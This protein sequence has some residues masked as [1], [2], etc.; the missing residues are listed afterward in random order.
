M[1]PTSAARGSFQGHPEL[2]AEQITLINEHSDFMNL[3]VKAGSAGYRG[4]VPR[5]GGTPTQHYSP[6]LHESHRWGIVLAGGDGVRLRELTRWVYGDDRPK[7][8]C[9]LLGHRTLFEA[10]RHRAEQNLPADHIIFALTR[11]HEVY[12]RDLLDGQ[13]SKRIVQPYNRGTAPAILYALMVLAQIDP[14]ASVSILPSDHYYAP[15]AAFKSALED[16]FESADQHS[17]SVVLLGAPPKGPETEYGWIQL[18]PAVDGRFGLFQVDSFLEKPPLPMAQK[19]YANGSLW[20]TFVMVGHVSAFLDIASATVPGLVE[21]LAPHVAE[22]LTGAEIQVPDSLYAQ[23]A[24]VDFSTRVLTP[25][26]DRLLTLRLEHIDWC[27]LG[28]PYRVLVTL[29]EKDGALPQW[30]KLWPQSEDEPH[31]A[32]AGA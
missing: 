20:N 24:P 8:F 2:P 21:Q 32:V 15:E 31:V 30:V 22:S 7:Q 16:A 3:V 14:E 10:T 23:L 19:L 27:D 4:K 28:D 5:I 29:L 13:S 18:G 9:P 11:A 25:A 6:A 17:D 1:K 12:Y 26:M